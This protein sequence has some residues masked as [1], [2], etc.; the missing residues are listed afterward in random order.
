[1]T[2]PTP[3]KV[4]PDRQNRRFTAVYIALTSER[5]REII[6]IVGAGEHL[7]QAGEDYAWLQ[8]LTLI[9]DEALQREVERRRGQPA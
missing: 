4:P 6:R 3:T 1:M 8:E 7:P 2:Y 5:A 9:V